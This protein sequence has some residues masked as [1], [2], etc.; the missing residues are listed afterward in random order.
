[1]RAADIRKQNQARNEPPDPE[2]L[3]EAP[4]LFIAGQTR[5][6]R[7]TGFHQLAHLLR[8]IQGPQGARPEVLPPRALQSESVAPK[9]RPGSKTEQRL[10]ESAAIVRPI[11]FAPVLLADPRE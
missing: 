4:C 6:D 3:C 5:V 10:P 2:L 8:R 7:A 1:M 9:P 11:P